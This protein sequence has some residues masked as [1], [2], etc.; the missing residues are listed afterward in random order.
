[1]FFEG[2]QINIQEMSPR[3]Y[4]SYIYNLSSTTQVPQ[5]LQDLEVLLELPKSGN[6]FQFLQDQQAK[7]EMAVNYYGEELYRTAYTMLVINMIY[8]RYP[9]ATEFL[10][11]MVQKTMAKNEH[12]NFLTFIEY[13]KDEGLTREAPIQEQGYLVNSVKFDYSKTSVAPAVLSPQHANLTR[14]EGATSS[15]NQSAAKVVTG[16]HIPSTETIPQLTGHSKLVSVRKVADNHYE[17][18]HS[19]PN[20]YVELG[21]QKFCAHCG[22]SHKDQSHIFGYE[23]SPTFV[24]TKVAHKMKAKLLKF[25]PEAYASLISRFFTKGNDGHQ[26]N[27]LSVSHEPGALTQVGM[28][29][30]N[31]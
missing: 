29:D 18:K 16:S 9:G 4:M 19:P 3:K 7:E 5:V 10:N 21:T 13:L 2:R 31:K 14:Y 23:E 30:L 20:G 24:N 22:L 25:N 28:A 8:S 15:K 1:M 6:F 17:R 12:V 27:Y 26:V 11:K